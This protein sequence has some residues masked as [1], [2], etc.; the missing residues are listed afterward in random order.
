[1]EQAVEAHTLRLPPVTAKKIAALDVLSYR[2]TSMLVSDGLSVDPSVRC[3][4][5]RLMPV[6]S[7]V[8][9]Y[10]VTATARVEVDAPLTNTV[11]MSFWKTVTFGI[12]HVPPEIVP[13]LPA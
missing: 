10:L 12:V 6:M 4:S 11:T 1:M 9:V 8:P 13:V 7:V 5:Y 2:P 3:I